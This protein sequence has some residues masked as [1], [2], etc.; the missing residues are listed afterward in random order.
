MVITD[1][2]H[3]FLACRTCDAVLHV[4][5]RHHLAAYSGQDLVRMMQESGFESVENER[6][7]INWMWGMMTARARAPVTA[8][9][10]PHE[11]RNSS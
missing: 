11:G 9:P 5:D 6:Y 3:D 8:C 4:F 10:S 7:R 2:C 1:W